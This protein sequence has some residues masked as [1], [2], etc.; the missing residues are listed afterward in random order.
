MFPI[1]GGVTFSGLNTV[2]HSSYYDDQSSYYSLSVVSP[3]EQF[4]TK[5]W[6]E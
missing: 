1:K 5:C 4:A 6:E 2:V 3:E